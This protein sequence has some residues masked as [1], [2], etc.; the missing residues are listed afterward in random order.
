MRKLDHYSVEG[1][2]DTE[3][4]DGCHWRGVKEWWDGI[5]RVSDSSTIVNHGVSGLSHRLRALLAVC[6]H[7]SRI[8]LSSFG[9]Q[10]GW[11]NEVL[12]FDY[13]ACPKPRSGPSQVYNP[14]T[15]QVLLLHI[16]TIVPRS[17]FHVV[18]QQLWVRVPRRVES[19]FDNL[20]AC[21]FEERR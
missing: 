11:E 14:S 21:F 5:E 2:T 9:L 19:I 18:K 4:I 3:G 15:E 16:G 12:L 20:M 1:G 13:G 8:A 10:S 7:H 17:V 6:R